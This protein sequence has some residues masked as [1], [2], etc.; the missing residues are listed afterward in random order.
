MKFY[1]LDIDYSDEGMLLFGISEDGSRIKTIDPTY[2]SYF[3]VL[4]SDIEQATKEIS[5]IIKQKALPVTEITKERKIFHGEEKI[6]IKIYTKRHQ[7]LQKVRDAVKM[8]ELNRGGSGSVIDEFEYQISAPRVYL[9]EQGF[10]CL[11]WLEGELTV[12]GGK[13]LIKD[14]KKTI[15]QKPNLKILAF[16]MEVIEV[17]RGVPSIIMISV[18]GEGLSKIITYQKT[19]YSVDSIIVNDEKSVIESFLQIIK[20]YDPDIICGYN[21]DLYDMP[22]L[23][24]RA[25]KL[26]VSID[27]LSRDNSGITLL[28][29]ARFT[30]ARLIGRVHIDIF[31]FVFNILSPMLQSE[32]LT[33]KNVAYELLE[34]TKLDMEYEDILQAWDKG[35]EL[36]KLAR[37]CLKDSEL[38]YKLAEMLLPDIEELTKITGQSLFDTSRMPY[39]QLVEWY[40][41]KKAK[42]QNRIIPN[43]PKF[44][45]IQMRRQITYE[46]GFVKEP[47]PGLHRNI[48]VVDF[49]SLYPSIIASYNISIETLNCSCCKDE[50]YK[51][52]ELPYWFCKNKRGF[53]SLAIEELL[54]ERLALKEKLKKLDPDSHEYLVLDTKQKALK[55]IINASYGYYAYPG[56]RWYS[57]ECAESITA[58]GRFWIKEVLKKA[59]ER[60][61]QVIY[62]DTDSV[63]LKFA[64][65]KGKVEAFIHEINDYLPGIMRLDLENFYAKGLFVPKETGGIAKKRYALLDEKGRLKIRGLEIVRRDLSRYAKQTQQEILKMCLIEENVKGAFKYLDERINN[66]KQSKYD[67]RDLVVYEQL[68]KPVSEYKLISPHVMAAK[69]L[70]EKEIPVGEGSVIGYIIQ[71]GT[72]SIS[73]RAYPVELA[74]PSKVDIDY[75][76]ENQI[77]PSAM[78]ILNVFKTQKLR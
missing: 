67:F 33:L 25:K 46:G 73:E 31:N 68:S 50:G 21:S 52:P 76:I 45:E 42:S 18:F 56:S 51:I 6:F 23:R 49:A 30:T 41:I 35:H 71:K 66:L 36:D 39:S 44:D 57:K 2:R 4:P 20:N 3:Y 16:D 38:V 22:V 78:R 64:E 34:D 61:F 12:K 11:E 43:Q 77:V 13:S 53:E 8:L 29:R 40:Y 7:D 47:Q 37:Y 24:E 60:G 55:T 17:Q 1:L 9:S 75:Y 74:E 58:L 28:K 70:L 48:A 15:W 62:G 5:E 27:S 14:I 10:S 65:D 72:G 69:R 32:Q 54:K 19:D 63:F 59:E 26:K